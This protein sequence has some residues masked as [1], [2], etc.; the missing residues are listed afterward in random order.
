MKRWKYRDS[1]METSK[2]GTKKEIKMFGH[3]VFCVFGTIISVCKQN[4]SVQKQFKNHISL[5]TTSYFART[6]RR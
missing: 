3:P 4:N 2:N 5:S 6:Q 1:I